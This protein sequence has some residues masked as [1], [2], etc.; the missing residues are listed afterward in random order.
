MPRCPSVLRLSCLDRRKRVQIPDAE[1]YEGGLWLVKPTLE[2]DEG[3]GMSGALKGG[4]VVDDLAD[5]TRRSHPA[6]DPARARGRSRR[7]GRHGGRAADRCRAAR[8]SARP[9]RRRRWSRPTSRCRPRT[10]GARTRRSCCR[11]DPVEV[12]ALWERLYEATIYPGR[13]GLGIHALSAIDIALHDL[14]G[15]QLDIPAYKLM[16]GARRPARPYCTIYPRPRRTADRCGS[17]WL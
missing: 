15:K 1:A 2:R 11:G 13:R 9:T 7:H 6:R 12:T 17:S 8:A 3:R 16:G 14:A 10:C 4:R 5:R